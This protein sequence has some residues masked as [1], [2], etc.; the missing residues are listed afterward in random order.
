[1]RVHPFLVLIALGFVISCADD[2]V[3]K[4]STP[5]GF[6]NTDTNNGDSNNG[7][8]NNASNNPQTTST[9][10]LARQ[11]ARMRPLRRWIKV[12]RVTMHGC[13]SM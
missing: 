13:V 7:D 12:Y 11:L 8:S 1:M 10:N 5:S 3:K 2:V 4:S 6:N 9:N